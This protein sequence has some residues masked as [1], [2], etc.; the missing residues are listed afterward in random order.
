M[1]DT[2]CYDS[3]VATLQCMKDENTPPAI[4]GLYLFFKHA[5]L[6]GDFTVCQ[7]C[8]DA[9]IDPNIGDTLYNISLLHEL[10]RDKRLTL[11]VAKFLIS[12]G[13]NINGN[14]KSFC[15][16]KTPLIAACSCGNIEI[17]KY[18]LEQGALIIGMN[19]FNISELDAAIKNNQTEIVK[20]LLEFGFN[21]NEDN[22]L[23][24][25]VSYNLY[26]I[27]K[28]LL[29]HGANLNVQKDDIYP[30]DIAIRKNDIAMQKLLTEYGGR[31]SEK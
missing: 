9:G 25:A 26:G 15:Y 24:T 21:P 3:L 6:I 20:F 12:N 27:T 2:N 17:V 22:Y 11:D 28:L 19:E 31:S 4:N 23:Y 16:Y 30:L 7:A 8:I 18:L 1:K 14:E 10:A 5:C 29:E 13:A